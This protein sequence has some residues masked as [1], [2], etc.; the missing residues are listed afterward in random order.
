MRLLRLSF[1]ACVYFC[2]ATILAEIGI[3]A[4]LGARGALT[5]EKIIYLT[6]IARG[7]DLAAFP[8][9]LERP[10]GPAHHEQ[11][12]WEEVLEARAR[13]SADLD[14]REMVADRGLSEVRQLESLLEQMRDRYTQLKASFDQRLERLH[15]GAADPS[16]L[17]VQ[18][19]LESVAPK[20]AKEQILRML[21]DQDIPPETTLRFVVS[22]FKRMPLDKRKK[23]LAEFKSEDMPRLHEI[24]RQLR[25]GVPEVTLFRDTRERLKKLRS[26]S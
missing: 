10:T 5:R 26:E 21:E 17:E 11:V 14:L 1:A 18:R 7:V 2:A 13:Q 25:L 3:L 4:A 20:L 19:E 8:T 22:M 6:A 24:L 12:S 16:L 23:I 9:S 15:Q